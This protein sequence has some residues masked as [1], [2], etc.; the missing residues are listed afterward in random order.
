MRSHDGM[1]W[2]EAADDEMYSIMLNNMCVM[3]DFPHRC[4][5]IGCKGI[6]RKKFKLDSIVEKYKA[7]LVAK[8]FTEKKDFDYFDTYALVARILTIRLLLAVASIKNLII[9]Q[10]DVKTVFLNG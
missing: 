3:V 5:T 7:R 9:Y 8:G 1:F 10:M 6:F 4:K 2:K